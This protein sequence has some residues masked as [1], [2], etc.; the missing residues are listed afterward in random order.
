MQESKRA[1]ETNPSSEYPS[2]DDLRS[3]A[4]ELI[5]DGET[6]RRTG[7]DVG[8]VTPLP[9]GELES[10]DSSAH[11]PGVDDPSH[12]DHELDDFA[13]DEEAIED[14]FQSLMQRISGT[15]PD[16]VAEKSQ[17]K[18]Q[19]AGGKDAKDVSKTGKESEPE[20]ESQK[21][22][23]PTRPREK[24]SQVHQMRE[25][26]N[27]RAREAIAASDTRC[28]K[29]VYAESVVAGV[30]M[31][32]AAGVLAMAS[33]VASLWYYTGIGLLCLSTVVSLRFFYSLRVLSR[34]FE[35]KKQAL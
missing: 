7:S 22:A 20:G 23:R 17:P 1:E 2:L 24:P 19:V 11:S 6:K 21:A 5:G 15:R 4:D 25:L 8:P 9:E 26:A 12:A 34:P 29:R 32:L 27:S 18:A 3:L 30:T 16:D 33:Q 13:D 10:V 35:S 31:T 14:Y 28:L